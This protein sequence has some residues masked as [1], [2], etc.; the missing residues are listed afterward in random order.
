M[1]DVSVHQFDPVPCEKRVASID[2][3]RGFAVLNLLPIH[4]VSFV[5]NGDPWM[6][7]GAVRL[8]VAASFV[9][10]F[11]SGTFFSLFSMLFGAGVVLITARAESRGSGAE[12][13]DIYY[14]RLLWLLLF[15]VIHQYVILWP[16]DILFWYAVCGLFLFPLRRLPPALL[17]AGGIMMLAA[18]IPSTISEQNEER[19]LRATAV[20][21]D[22][23]DANGQPLTGEQKKAQRAWANMNQVE[24]ADEAWDR[25]NRL[26]Y[27]EALGGD[28]SWSVT[29][30]SRIL[31]LYGVFEAGGMMLLGMAFMK[32]GVFSAIRSVRFYIILLGIGYGIGLTLKIGWAY[33]DLA[34]R[35]DRGHY[36]DSAA[37]LVFND[38]VSPAYGGLVALGHIAALTLILRWGRL[39]CFAS[40]LASVGRMALSN[41]V[42]QS[43]VITL[44]LRGYGLA[45]YD[46]I[47]RYQMFYVVAV[48]WPIQLAVSSIWLK[49]FRF[50]PLEWIWRSLTYW[51]PQRM[52]V[53]PATEGLSES[54]RNVFDRDASQSNTTT[55]LRYSNRR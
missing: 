36:Y 17:I 43:L 24:E 31:Y 27:W 32:L 54:E 10:E 21:A 3:L 12:I 33:Y 46:E 28:L 50:G 20:V 52:I 48:V 15:G 4:L 40:I 19:E 45:L 38:A 29:R 14:R 6:E 37:H 16:G 35:P 34:F 51:H 41:Y 25:Y 39:T 13:G 18:F 22:V 47:Q 8:N 9:I 5:S 42:A 26:G 53:Q 23:R 7:G 11:L 44:L 2:V 55:A 49:H 30:Q 1:S